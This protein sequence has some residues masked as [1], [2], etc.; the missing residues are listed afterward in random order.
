MSLNELAYVFWHWPKSGVSPETYEAKLKSFHNRLNASRPS[1]L[2][3]A[4]SY[5]AST[6]PWGPQSG[7][8]YEDWYVVRDFAALEVLNDAAVSGEVRGSHDSIAHEY[9]KG[10][11]GVYKLINGNLDR[12]QVKFATW[13]EKTIG[14]SYE[15]YYEELNRIL[16]NH[17]TDLWRRQLVL[18]PSPQF[19]VH[20]VDMVK[21][22]DSF[23]PMTVMMESLRLA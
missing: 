21:L 3:R 5:R 2:F 12:D 13:I 16:G 4:M 8:V 22:P 15:S 17:A 14:P 18:G 11:G 6:I 1:G 23:K 7:Q 10:A 19:V 20:S 9:L